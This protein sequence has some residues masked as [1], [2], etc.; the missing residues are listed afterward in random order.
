MQAAA[1]YFARRVAYSVPFL[2]RLAERF[3]SSAHQG[4]E[5]WDKAL[6]GWAKPYMGQTPSID[7]RN[8]I[9]ATMV[10]H[11]AP[12]NPAVLDVG[13]AGGTLSLVLP[14]FA[15]YVGTDISPY[16]VEQA[17]QNI[18]KDNV[19]F[20]AADLRD[21]KITPDSWDVIVFAELLY[22]LAV[23]EAVEAVSRY[24][25]GLK[26]DGTIIVSMKDEGGKSGAIFKALSKRFQWVD[27]V[28]WQA[29][30]SGPN[31][32]TAANRERPPF[33]IAVLRRRSP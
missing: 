31:Y 11:H 32:Q 23:D 19:A 17:A 9:I 27:A 28:L 2:R 22:F 29:K 25:A 8:A 7:T 10:K 3:A 6:S 12:A 30:P 33:L 1:R 26:K 21:F 24:A 5:Y 20:E 18:R 4:A 16:A 13:C 14:P 15:R